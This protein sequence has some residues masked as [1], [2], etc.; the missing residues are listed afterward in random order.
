MKST[1]RRAEGTCTR[2]IVSSDDCAKSVLRIHAW[3]VRPRLNSRP[4]EKDVHIHSERSMS[5]R[6]VPRKVA[7]AYSFGSAFAAGGSTEARPMTNFLRASAHLKH[8][9]VNKPSAKLNGMLD[10]RLL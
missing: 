6:T 4:K 7:K 9:P 8:R 2:Q 3:K 5:A 10:K 1:E